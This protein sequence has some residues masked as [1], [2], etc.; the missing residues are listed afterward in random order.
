MKKI[1]NRGGFTL[2]ELLAVIVVLAIIILMAATA[3]VP[4]METARKQVFA[5]E[6]ND[7]I[8]AASSYFMANSINGSGG[9]TLPVEKDTTA[10][11]TIADL[12]DTGDFDA[13]ADK[14]YGVVCVKKI[15]TSNKYVYNVA[16]TNSSHMVLGAG[17]KDITE[18]DV[19]GFDSSALSS[20]GIAKNKIT[21]ST[22]LDKMQF[23]GT[24][25]SGS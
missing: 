11:V 6:C 25:T 17:A 16:M 9:D 24:T 23:G 15:G 10:C 1:K 19:S 21:E 2:I 14:Y 4:R 18:K 5:L 13:D 22:A 20:W 7:A 12:I 8:N 3:I